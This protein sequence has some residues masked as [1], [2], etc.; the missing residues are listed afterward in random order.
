MLPIIDPLEAH[1]KLTV[2]RVRRIEYYSLRK[3]NPRRW[4]YYFR[5]IHEP[6]FVEMDRQEVQATKR[7]IHELSKNSRLAHNLYLR[8]AMRCVALE[9]IELSYKEVQKEL[10]FLDEMGRGTLDMYVGASGGQYQK[11]EQWRKELEMLE[12]DY[13]ERIAYRKR[14]I[15]SVDPAWIEALPSRIRP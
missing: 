2:H 8:C 15:A 12:V 4:V 9:R 14:I 5:M 3:D 1:Q 6:I 11:L 13:R 7:Y 10:A